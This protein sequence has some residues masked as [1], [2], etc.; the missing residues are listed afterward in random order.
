MEEAGIETDEDVLFVGVVGEEGLGD[1]RGMKHIF[2]DPDPAP[3]AW[4]EVDGGGLTRLVTDGLGSVRYRVTFAGP[5][6]H[7][8]GAFGLANPAHAMSR[9]VRHFQDAADTLTTGG[10][11]HIWANE[12]AFYPDTRIFTPARSATLN[13]SDPPRREC[14][15]RPHRS[16]SRHTPHPS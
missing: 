7:S 14:T 8:R 3:D 6:G 12:Q 1:L 13:T 2:R 5:G 9:A 4:I 10:P 11:S 16:T 15:A